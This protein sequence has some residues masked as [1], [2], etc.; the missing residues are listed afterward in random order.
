MGSWTHATISPGTAVS[1][2]IQDGT[3]RRKS[4]RILEVGDEQYKRRVF[5][6]R[7]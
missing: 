3:E 1:N 7:G 6:E 5:R 4:E 2:L